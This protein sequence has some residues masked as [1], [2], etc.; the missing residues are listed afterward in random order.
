MVKKIEEVRPG[1]ID[2]PIARA[3]TPT[4][5]NDITFMQQLLGNLGKFNKAEKTGPAGPN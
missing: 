4:H 5:G 3:K 2:F 1:H